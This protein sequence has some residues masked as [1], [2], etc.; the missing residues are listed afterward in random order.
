MTAL[1]PLWLLLTYAALVGAVLGSYVNVVVWRVP[2]DIST[3]RPPSACPSCGHAIAWY[4]NV[5]VVSWLALRGRCRGCSGRISVRYPLVEAGVGALFA[6][7][8]AAL[9]DQ[10]APLVLLAVLA[11][12]AGGTALTLIDLEHHR[13]PHKVTIATAVGI[14]VPL[15]AQAVLAGAWPDLLRAGIGAAAL[16]VFY[17]AAAVAYPGGMGGGD[18]RLAP[19]LGFILGWFGVAHLVVGAIAPFLIGGVAIAVLA[20]RGRARKGSGV[21]F[22]PFM[23]V[24]TLGSLLAAPAVTDWYLAVSGLA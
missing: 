5:P 6:A 3:A 9:V 8:T 11:L 22:G 16:F 19:V 20:A 10:V 21:P 7:L 18:I 15:L 24:G 2:R 1:L 12:A 4:D 13:L 23:T 14:V 17:L